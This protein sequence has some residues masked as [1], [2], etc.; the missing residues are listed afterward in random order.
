[1]VDRKKRVVGIV[2]A[3]IAVAIVFLIEQIVQ[4]GYWVKSAIKVVCFVGAIVIY[5]VVSGK[6]FT[7]VINL[8][9]ITNSKPLLICMACFFLGIGIL[10]ALLRNQ[11]DL[12]SI[13]ESLITKE[14][15]TKSNCLFVFAYII[16][17]N[18]FLEESFFRGFFYSLFENKKVG[19]VISGLVFSLYHIGIVITWFNPFIFALCIA[20]L[21]VVGVFLQWLSSKYQS[22]M[23][24]WITHACANI[25]INTI[26][27][28]MIFGVLS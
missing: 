24:S 12:S 22:I 11:I 5:S 15:L 4:P 28:L 10:F 17:V 18:S 8:K 14:N 9:K 21:A 1:M 3:L 16:V 6:R 19:A 20:G 7:D 25:A 26:G 23:A 2:V 27:A 13:K